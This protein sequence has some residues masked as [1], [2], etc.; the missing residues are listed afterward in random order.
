M[1]VIASPDEELQE[2][3]DDLD[4]EPETVTIPNLDQPITLMTVVHIPMELLLLLNS[5]DAEISGRKVWPG[6]AF[7]AT[8]LC[9]PSPPVDLA[10]A[11]AVL[12]LGCGSGLAEVSGSGSLCSVVSDIAQAT[13]LARPSALLKMG[14]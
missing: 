3:L 8:A 5:L 4:Y 9:Q 11:N 13:A 7:L 2:L 12:E 14:S 10:A 1:E 6:S